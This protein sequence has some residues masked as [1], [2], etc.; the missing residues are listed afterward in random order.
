MV[1]SRDVGGKVR[2]IMSI[3]DFLHAILGSKL[4]MQDVF[5]VAT[6]QLYFQ[7]LSLMTKKSM[8]LPIAERWSF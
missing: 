8:S 4:H 1:G 3:L 5:F 7:R 6:K 2:P